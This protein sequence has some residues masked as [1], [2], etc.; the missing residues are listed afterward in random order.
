MGR[1]RSVLAL[2]LVVAGCGGGK[3]APTKPIAKP[4]TKPAR[5]TPP[6]ETEAD[7][8]QKR[9]AAAVAIVP[10]GA[11]CLPPAFK[12]DGAPRL[13]LV[14]VGNGAV[15]CAIDTDRARLLGPIACWKLNLQTGAL[16]YQDPTPMPG[17]GFDVLLDDRC[18]RGFCLPKDA[19][20]AGAKLAHVAWNLD[21]TKVA[22]LVG[23]DVHLF[24]AATKAHQSSFTIRGDK[25]V[26]NDPTA[27]HFVGDMLFVE[28]ADQGPYSAVWM[29]KADGTQM[30]PLTA[31]GAKDDK[32]M[33]TYHGAFAI[34]DVNRVA[35]AEKGYE[36]VTI[37]ELA[38]GKRA[39]LVRKVAKPACKAGELDQ[40]WH[41][42]DKVTDR[43]K[44][45][46]NKIY[47]HLM[48]ATT[49]AGNTS[50]LAL[51]RNDRLGELAVLDAKTLAEK[52]VLRMPWCDKGDK[53]DAAAAPADKPEKAMKK[54]AASKSK[55][56]GAAKSSD[57]DEGGE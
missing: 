14:A 8:E 23:D 30:G 31:I 10:E 52:R 33:S 41:D 35:I 32:P 22:V 42:G 27:V 25:G 39:K 6:P 18:A 53:G 48:G 19:K 3:K 13:E 24:D 21:S 43:C 16:S 49:I 5:P 7:R 29:F 44:D 56:K 51:L 26:S 12:D 38:T 57:P 17:R 1:H 45:G 47:G 54:D 50:L 2:V 34:L 9:H 46:L 40:F 4:E 28:G 36:S 15:V 11:S 37:V 55:A 20:L